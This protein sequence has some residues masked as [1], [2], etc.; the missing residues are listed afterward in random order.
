MKTLEECRKE[1][2]EIDG[3]LVEL[4]QQRM[5][6]SM[7]VATYKKANDIP[8]YDAEREQALLRRI[9]LLAGSNHQDAILAVYDTILM[10]SKK[11][12]MELIG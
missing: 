12:Q 3:K 7:D 5:Y 4:L 10:E 11:K 8:V 1:I 9:A 6:V 2:N